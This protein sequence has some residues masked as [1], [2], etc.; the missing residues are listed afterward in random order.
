MID[1]SRY[2]DHPYVAELQELTPKPG[3]LRLVDVLHDDDCPKL[4]GGACRCDPI[5]RPMNRQER[6]A[7]EKGTR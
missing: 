4:I 3:T 5:V 1:S 7:Y 6:R 2:A